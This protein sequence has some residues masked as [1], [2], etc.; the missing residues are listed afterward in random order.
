MISRII[1]IFF[2]FMMVVV[3]MMVTLMLTMMVVVRKMKMRMQ[4]HFVQLVQKFSFV[5]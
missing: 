4:P 1:K 2:G 3:M 5:T